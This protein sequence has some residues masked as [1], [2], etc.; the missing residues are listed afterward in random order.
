MKKNVIIFGMIFILLFP[1]ISAVEFNINQN[2]S[3][4]ETIIA[5][6]SGNFLTPITNNNIFFYDG[7]TQIPMVYNV[8]KAG[9]DYYFY[10]LTS[11]KSAG[12]YSVSV[13]NVQYMKGA[14]VVSDNI[15]ANFSITNNT[16][17]FSVKPGAISTSGDF[18][19][20]V[21]NLQDRQI[22]INVNNL[23]NSSVREIFSSDSSLQLGSGEIKKI[24]F[25]LGDGSSG[26]RTIKLN[27][28]NFTYQIP[29]YVLS[30]QMQEAPV[31]SFSIDPPQ[32]FISLPTNTTIKRTILFYNTGN[33]DLQN[34]SIS[35]PDSLKSSLNLSNYSLN[36]LSVKSGIPIDL[37]FFSLSEQKA[38]GYLK[39]KSG[40]VSGTFLVSVNFVKNLN[41]SNQS[42]SIL[43]KTCAQF[44]GTVCAYGEQC[45]KTPID[46]KDSNN[47]CLG[48]CAKPQAG[49]SG[50]TI[51]IILLAV[52]FLIMIFFYL[53]YKKAK[54][55]PVNLLEV[56]KE[57]KF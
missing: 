4:G 2:F 49:S 29:V 17:A 47:C 12:D 11:G 40:N 57:K 16:V 21:Q 1:I 41:V 14:E 31:Q 34:I 39:A 54:R 43:T 36:N 42:Q 55:K 23:A 24:S 7:H 6:L 46:A 9:N 56:A 8:V 5:K 26:L 19:I 25:T 35:L 51:G 27:S 15:G 45:D 38:E 32:L 18:S 44:N 33:Y 22:T 30:S 10:A 13:Q 28:G 20:E 37:F 3:Q 53:K 48:N 52:V 50:Q